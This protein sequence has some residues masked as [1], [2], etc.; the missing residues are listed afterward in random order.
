MDPA[1]RSFNHIN[2]D[3]YLNRVGNTLPR[4][5]QGKRA[6]MLAYQELDK[7]LR[8]GQG[9]LKLC[10]VCGLQGSGKSSW[11]KQ[12]GHGLGD[13]IIFLDAALPSRQARSK[14]LTI[15]SDND[16]RAIAV[17]VHAPLKLA[18][19]RNALRPPEQWVP[20][21][22]IQHTHE[23]WQ[24]PQLDE[25]FQQVIEIDAAHPGMP[26]RRTWE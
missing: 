21:T 8:Q 9:Q 26:P 5:E 13:R 10:L 25:G 23:L 20:E 14:A 4:P 12:Y 7:K 11:I 6:W 19:A 3:H 18:L 24:P 22:I 2:P 16:S 1:P 15:A 17:W